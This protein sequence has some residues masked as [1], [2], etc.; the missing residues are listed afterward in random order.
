MSMSEKVISYEYIRQEVVRFMK[1]SSNIRDKYKN[2][3]ID[4][5]LERKSFSERLKSHHTNSI[6]MHHS[7]HH[8]NKSRMNKRPR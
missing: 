2:T 8:I 3:F 4:A 7:S 1:S 5:C 6:L